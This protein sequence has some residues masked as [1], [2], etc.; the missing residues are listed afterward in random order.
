MA[1]VFNGFMALVLIVFLSG[2]ATIIKPKTTALEVNSEPADANVY[3][4]GVRVGRTPLTTRVSNKKQ[5][6]VVVKKDGYE[7][8]GKN[9]PT[10]MAWGYFVLDIIFWPGLIV[11]VIC[12]DNANTLNET[13]VSFYLEPK[14][15]GEKPLGSGTSSENNSTTPAKKTDASKCEGV[16]VGPKWAECMGLK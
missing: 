10:H 5:L 15:D 8:I 3:L 1:K 2:C 16:E 12:H 4:D 9:I 14:R 6:A 7:E 11:D 13:K